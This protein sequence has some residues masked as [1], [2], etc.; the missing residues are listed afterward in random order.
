MLGLSCALSC[1]S[2]TAILGF[3]LSCL[4]EIGARARYD[5]DRPPSARSRMLGLPRTRWMAAVG[6]IGD[7]KVASEAANSDGDSGYGDQVGL[8]DTASG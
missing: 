2:C 4:V 1:R 8:C 3:S 6:G 7:D 5:R